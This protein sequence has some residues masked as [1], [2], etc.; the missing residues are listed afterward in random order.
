MKYLV[1]PL[2]LLISYGYAQEINNTIT[3]AKS[4]K[5]YLIGVCNKDGFQK[6]GFNNYYDT[7]YSN[8]VPDP[9]ILN[10]LSQKIAG[11]SITIVMATWCH[12]SHLQVP[13]FYKILDQ[14][15]FPVENIQLICVDKEKRAGK[16][17]ISELNIKRVPTI[18]FLR[19]DEEQGRIIESPE[20]S[21]EKDMLKYI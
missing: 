18:I 11:L 20:K 16:L 1:L 17:S 10:E 13:R 21:L 4:D 19:T 15:K 2:I 5:D 14:L 12:D 3:D 6:V 9:E 7:A 8:Y